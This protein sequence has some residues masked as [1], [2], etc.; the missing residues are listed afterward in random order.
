MKNSTPIFRDR[1]HA[2]QVLAARLPAYRGQPHCQV[3]GLARGGVPVAYEVALALDLPLDVFVVRKLGIPGNEELA[4]GAIA[5]GGIRVLNDEVVTH[6]RDA[7][8]ILAEVTRRE[9]AE[10]RRR[11]ER[12]RGNRVFTPVRHRTVL[13]VDDGLAT[14]ATMRAAIQSLR[15]SGVE[16]C[17]VAVPVAAPDTCREFEAEAHDIICART[18]EPFHSVGDFYEDFAQTSDEEVYELLEAAA[19]RSRRV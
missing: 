12:Y 15:L 14:G 17:V 4:M 2:G 13:L 19:H 18:P 5:S 11:E 1:R 6:L 3:L 7:D 9:Q 10:L 8:Q 16:R